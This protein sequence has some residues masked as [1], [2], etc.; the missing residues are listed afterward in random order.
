M[1]LRESSGKIEGGCDPV[2]P[3]GFCRLDLRGKTPRTHSSNSLKEELRSNRDFG[4]IPVFVP[5]IWASLVVPEAGVYTEQS[6]IGELWLPRGARITSQ[7]WRPPIRRAYLRCTCSISDIHNAPLPPRRA[8]FRITVSCHWWCQNLNAIF[9]SLPQGLR[10][11][12]IV[13]RP[14]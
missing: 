6:G 14:E 3:P 4:R 11:G 13:N 9:S 10:S 5:I 12:S 7:H 2:R 1:P 8:T